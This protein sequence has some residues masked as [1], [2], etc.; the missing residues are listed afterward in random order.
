MEQNKV[1]FF[2]LAQHHFSLPETVLRFETISSFGLVSSVISFKEIH[3]NS[4]TYLKWSPFYWDWNTNIY[5]LL[6]LFISIFFYFKPIFPYGLQDLVVACWVS[7]G[8]WAG[9]N[10]PNLLITYSSKIN[11]GIT[12][13]LYPAPGFT[14]AEP[15]GSP[16]SE[17]L[18]SVSS[19]KIL[20]ASK[21]K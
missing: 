12:G 20:I 9:L 2:T 15:K 13:A 11:H 7:Y 4:D 18:A 1:S 6:S 3:S 21:R 14:L 8:I 16:T 10:S 5:C 17:Q 19:C